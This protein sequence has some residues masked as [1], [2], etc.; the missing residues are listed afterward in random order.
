[1]NGF[2][3]REMEIGPLTAESVNGFAGIYIGYVHQSEFQP[4]WSGG[5]NFAGIYVKGCVSTVFRKPSCQSQVRP[6]T[7]IPQSGLVVTGVTGEQTSWCLFD[8]PIFEY[9]PSGIVLEQALG[10]AFVSGTAE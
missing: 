3:V 7:K 6:F 4:M 2:G 8:M 9:V 5:A 10:N 1:V